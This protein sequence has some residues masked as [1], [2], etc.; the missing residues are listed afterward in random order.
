MEALLNKFFKSDYW[1]GPI[2]FL[3]AMWFINIL[4]GLMTFSPVGELQS[5][6][7]QVSFIMPLTAAIAWWG[8]SVITTYSEDS[9][10][11]VITHGHSQHL[12]RVKKWL[13]TFFRMKS[14]RILPLIVIGT[15]PIVFFYAFINEVFSQR[16]GFNYRGILFVQAWITWVFYFLLLYVVYL[17]QRL[18]TMHLKKKMRIRLFEI[19]QFSPLCHLTILNFF[20]PCLIITFTTASALLNPYSEFDLYV[21]FLSFIV[22]LCFL[23]YPMFTI[24]HA[25]GVRREQSL[26]RL[27]KVLN[28][29]IESTEIVDNRRLVDDFERLQYVSDLLTVRKEINS[30]SLWPMD[31]P[32]VVKM[33]MIAMIPIL[34]WVG[35]GIVSQLLKTIS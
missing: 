13:R 11:K 12:P 4:F 17:G 19:E 9:L 32:F 15:L 35:A 14:K 7:A 28:I 25:L 6:D 27:N 20:I 16:Y 29:Q 21:A 18:I 30:M 2:T 8:I 24:R 23:T 22:I 26:K 3:T 33:G 10:A 5:T 34:S 1:L 31:V